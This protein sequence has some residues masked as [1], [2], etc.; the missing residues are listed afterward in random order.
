MSHWEVYEWL[1][2]SRR[3]QTDIIHNAS[4]AFEDSVIMRSLLSVQEKD[5]LG[6]GMSVC[7]SRCQYISPGHHWKIMNKFDM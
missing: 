3:K 1:E 2:R 6:M 4:S 5:C 7:L